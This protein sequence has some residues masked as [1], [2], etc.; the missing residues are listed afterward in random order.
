MASSDS[1]SKH[2]KTAP[3]DVVPKKTK[4]L[5]GISLTADNTMGNGAHQLVNPIYNIALGVNPAWLGMVLAGGRL[6]DAVIDP[7]VGNFSDNFRSRFGR[8]RPLIVA[9]AALCGIAFLLMF[10]MPRGWSPVA[11]IAY[12][13]VCTFVYFTA[14]TLLAVPKAAMSIELTPDYH[15]RTRVSAVG[16]LFS[17]LGG[18]VAVWLFALTKLDIF[19][20]SIEGVKWVALGVGIYILLIGALPAYFV[21]ERGYTQVQKQPKVGFVASLSALR[22]NTPLLLIGAAG[23]FIMTGLFTVFSLGLYLNIYYVNAG[24]TKV[25]SIWHGATGTAYQLASILAAAPIGYIATKVGKRTALIG[26]VVV[27]LVGTVAKWYCFTPSAPWL[28]FIPSILMGTGMAGFWVLTVAM[29][30]D[31]C[32]YEEV[33]SGIRREAM[34]TS[35][36]TWIYK[37]GM[38][39]AYFLSGLVLVWTGFSS[40]LGGD[41]APATIMGMRILYTFVPAAALGLALICIWLYPINETKAYALR[42]ELERLRR[43]R[44]V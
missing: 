22:R 39:V 16:A 10:S 3:E 36:N 14:Y 5:F 44:G 12:L 27:A 35:V 41:Q 40:H 23:M 4:A 28:M 15:E 11:Y 37:T 31:V 26:C 33:R 43:T 25:A 29:M 9:G 6:F 19:A 30:A 32:D 7:F 2:H 18:M 21:R 1:S 17:P 38:S 24:D 20:D 34:L 8:R 42:A 13:S